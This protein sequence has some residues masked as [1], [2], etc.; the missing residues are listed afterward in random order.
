MKLEA[1]IGGLDVAR[2]DGDAKVEITGI[3]YDSRQT[4]PGHLFFS[5]ARDAQR[6]RANINDALS[7]GARALVVRGWDGEMARPAVTIVE[8]ERP[9]LLMGG[10]AARFF[11]APSERV[12]LIGITG[13]S[14]KTT[15]SYLLGA[16]F[17]AA[18]IPAGIIGTIGIFVAGKKI[19]SGLTTP[20]S[21]DFE[22]AL[23][24]M[25]REGVTHAAAEIS[26]IGI[27]E[28][29]V[30]ALNFR[31]CMFTNLGR[32]HL[33][34]HGTI[35]N[36]FAAKLRLFTEILPRSR[37]AEPV[38][39]VRGDDPFGRRVL[40][41]IATRK[42]SFGFDRTLDVFPENFSADLSG[43]RA[44]LSV[45]GKKIEIE[46]PLVGEINLLNILGAS[47]LSV[48]LGIETAAVADGVRRCPGAPG[49]LESVAVKPGVTV[50]VDYAHKP[51]ALEAVLNA[52]RRLCTGRIICVFGCGGDRDRG[53]RP[54]MGEIAGRI[55]DLPVLTSDNPRSEDPLA[56]I[57]E[58]EA[59]LIAAGLSRID[60]R[61]AADASSRGYIVEPDRRRAIAAA[62]RI[63]APGDAVIVAGKGHEDYQL[64]GGRV[65]PFDDRAVVR[66]IAAE[67]DRGQS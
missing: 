56:I 42:V 64:V 54:I 45:L 16:I 23:A 36:Y 67:L 4:M 25:E 8:S 37:R 24:R 61:A 5:M 33:D 31:A 19:Y 32:D 60:D 6:N 27:E 10:A 30:D 9:R 21:L 35:E 29:R 39:I 18:G 43:I 50:L 66:E 17:E 53:K 47:A 49:R 40:D 11:N 62:L 46:S 12:D 57:A 63:A 65:L 44:T 22:S 58:V 38:A 1:L 52:I 3:S 41:S 13:T 15:T 26:S 28:G 59:G 48:A 7:R 20:E 34:Y 14:G 2:I 55:A 51:D